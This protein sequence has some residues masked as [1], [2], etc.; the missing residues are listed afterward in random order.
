V[1]SWATFRLLGDSSRPAARVSQ[2][3]GLTSSHWVEAAVPVDFGT[4]AASDAASS[5][6]GLSSARRPRDG[7]DLA[8][9]LGCV[10][11]HLEPVAGTVWGLVEDG[12][13]AN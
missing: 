1:I 9:A 3:L 13:W 5:V 8:A 6:W 7:V 10:L 12:Y 11:D 4:P 2:R